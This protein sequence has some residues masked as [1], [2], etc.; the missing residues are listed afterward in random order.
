MENNNL[1]SKNSKE[2]KH[3]FWTFFN[4]IFSKPIII[5]LLLILFTFFFFNWEENQNI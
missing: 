5:I 4:A 1:I 3:N 2:E